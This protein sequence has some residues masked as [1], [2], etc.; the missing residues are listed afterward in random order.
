MAG[1]LISAVFYNMTYR[2]WFYTLCVVAIVIT[3]NVKSEAKPI[4]S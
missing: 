2:H 3:K 4:H 1:F